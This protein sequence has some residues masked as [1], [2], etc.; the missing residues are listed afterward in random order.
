M[1]L[2]SNI[3]FFF[4]KKFVTCF[5]I[6][7]MSTVIF[8]LPP[9]VLPSL[10]KMFGAEI[11]Y[12]VKFRQGTRFV[13]LSSGGFTNL[14]VGNN[15]YF[16]YECL[17]DLTGKVTIED[18]VALSPRCTVLTHQDVGNR[19]LSRIYSA[20]KGHTKLK[21]GC[22]IGANATILGGVEV[23]EN[24]VVSAGSLVIKNVE[25]NTVVGGVPA[26]VIKNICLRK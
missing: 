22:W 17:I 18:N 2:K 25:K 8:L 3:L 10:L 4:L 15:C 12:D 5:G 19:P 16:G 24:S 23:G 26:S 13:N 6:E 9:W 20:K 14:Q 7:P 1:G 21:Q 11:G